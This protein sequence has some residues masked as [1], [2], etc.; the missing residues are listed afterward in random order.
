MIVSYTYGFIANQNKKQRI[1][2]RDSNFVNL[3][4]GAIKVGLSPKSVE[5]AWNLGWDKY[6][7]N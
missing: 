4:D 1:P 6:N 5:N 7:L 2:Y 3:L